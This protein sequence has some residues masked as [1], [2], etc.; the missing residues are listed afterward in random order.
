MYLSGKLNNKLNR[1][2]ERALCIAY[3][4]NC[5]NFYPLLQRDKSVTIHS[6]NC[7]YLATVIF[8]TF[9]SPATMIEIFKFCDNTTYNR[10]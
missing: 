1:F 3:N 10:R 7:Q 9:V 4:D 2:Q 8:K 6:K 5:S